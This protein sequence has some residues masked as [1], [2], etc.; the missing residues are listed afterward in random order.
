M[1]RNKTKAGHKWPQECNQWSVHTINPFIKTRR[2]YYL[3]PSST[4]THLLGQR[5]TIHFYRPQHTKTLCQ[6]TD[7][8]RWCG[9]LGARHR[10]ARLTRRLRLSR[11]FVDWLHPGLWGVK[12]LKPISAAIS[13]HQN[14][15]NL[16]RIT[17]YRSRTKLSQET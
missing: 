7:K 3:K 15:R 6:L 16:N 13:G 17:K 8:L 12:K 9:H 2:I 10:A 5:R 1:T 11:S 14:K 4:L